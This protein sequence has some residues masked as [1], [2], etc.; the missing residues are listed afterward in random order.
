MSKERSP[1]ESV[2]KLL[3]VLYIDMGER[4][5][6]STA[7]ELSPSGTH[8]V[9]E[10]FDDGKGHSGAIASTYTI[11][12]MNV[13]RDALASGYIIQS[14]ASRGI[15]PPNRFVLSDLGQQAHVARLEQEQ[16]VREAE[17]E[18]VEIAH[19]IPEFNND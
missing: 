19:H 14:R 16:R 2:A 10:Y 4:G 15:V 17:E 7:I 12:Q 5:K 11:L 9:I 1:I 3:E 13:F 18:Q 8:S 6:I